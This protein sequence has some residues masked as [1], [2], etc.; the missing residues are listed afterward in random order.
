[1]SHT[2]EGEEEAHKKMFRVKV[3]GESDRSRLP[4]M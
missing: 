1:M 4:K 3:L 2:K